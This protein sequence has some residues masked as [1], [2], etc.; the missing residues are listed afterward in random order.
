MSVVDPPVFATSFGGGGRGWRF[1]PGA[2]WA[3]IFHSKYIVVGCSK[4][5]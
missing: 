3:L 5:G 1:G 2:F 4:G